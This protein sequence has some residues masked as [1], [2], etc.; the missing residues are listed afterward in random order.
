[1]SNIPQNPMLALPWSKTQFEEMKTTLNVVI[2]EQEDRLR[3]AA[4]SGIDVSELQ[5]QLKEHKDTLAK[6]IDAWKDKY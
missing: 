5:R 2:P 4:L 3:R 6:L 1:M